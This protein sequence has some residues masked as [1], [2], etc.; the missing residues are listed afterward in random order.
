[1]GRAAYRER[2][3][4]AR[5]RGRSHRFLD[6]HR[7]FGLTTPI[8]TASDAEGVGRVATLDLANLPRTQQ[9]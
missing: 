1:M 7:S 3:Q 9:S 6:E 4:P 8:I 2:A 5:G